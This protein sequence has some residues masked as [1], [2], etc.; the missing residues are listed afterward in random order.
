M[1][2]PPPG[3]HAEPL[4]EER[5][6]ATIVFA[7]LSGYTAVSERLD[8]ERIKSM[9]DDARERRTLLVVTSDRRLADYVR[10]SGVRVQSSG[11][12][13][14]RLDAAERREGTRPPDSEPA[15]MNCIGCQMAMVSA[16]LPDMDSPT[17]ALPVGA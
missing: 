11:E 15:K 9:V 5:R 1:G 2:G 17:T 4:P 7:D 13:R 14:K 3:A 6:K 16:A 8:P 10:R 12:F